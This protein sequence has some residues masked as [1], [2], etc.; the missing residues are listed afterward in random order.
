MLVRSLF[1]CFFL[2]CQELSRVKNSALVVCLWMHCGYSWSQ[3]IS[4]CSSS[5]WVEPIDIVKASSPCLN[6]TLMLLS[7]SLPMPFI[8]SAFTTLASIVWLFNLESLST[9]ASYAPLPAIKFCFV[10]QLEDL[11]FLGKVHL[12]GCVWLIL[13]GIFCHLIYIFNINSLSHSLHVLFS[14]PPLLSFSS[15]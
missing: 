4:K 8:S 1:F 5:L 15:I 9:G 11:F 13:W 10:I 7:S 2:I 6:S 14:Y 3:V 12:H